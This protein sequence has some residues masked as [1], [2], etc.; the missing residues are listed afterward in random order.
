MDTDT[1]ADLPAADR[2][3]LLTLDEARQAV[4]LLLH[5]EDD[6]EEGR[7]AGQLGADL[8]RRLPSD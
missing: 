2:H 6:T 4:E 8:A 5:F 1:D 3:P 7:A